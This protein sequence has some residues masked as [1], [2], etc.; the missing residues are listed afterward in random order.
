MRDKTC[1][2]SVALG[3]GSDFSFSTSM[4]GRQQKNGM[5]D[6]HRFDMGSDGWITQAAQFGQTGIIG[7]SAALPHQEVKELDK[8]AAIAYAEEL[9][10]VSRVI[11][12]DPF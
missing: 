11:A 12:V 7:Q 10:N 8:A 4:K 5:R 1:I 9:L 2:E 3:S 6:V